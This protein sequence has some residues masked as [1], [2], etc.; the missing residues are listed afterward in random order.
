MKKI[1]PIDI[2]PQQKLLP[3][4]ATKNKQTRK[5]FHIFERRKIRLA[6]KCTN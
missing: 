1:R 2:S 5:K 3:G 4:Q 6:N